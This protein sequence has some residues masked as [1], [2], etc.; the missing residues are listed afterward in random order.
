MRLSTNFFYL[1]HWNY[2]RLYTKDSYLASLMSL[3]LGLPPLGGA[4][5]MQNFLDIMK[6]SVTCWKNM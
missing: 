2:T 6:Y 4:Y 3:I 5:M 1:S